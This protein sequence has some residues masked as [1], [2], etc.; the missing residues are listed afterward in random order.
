[1]SVPQR[2][3]PRRRKVINRWIEEFMKCGVV[4]EQIDFSEIPEKQ[5]EKTP[6][7]VVDEETSLGAGAVIE[8]LDGGLYRLDVVHTFR[9]FERF[10]SEH[11]YDEL[12]GNLQI[13]GLKSTTCISLR[14]KARK[15]AGG[16]GPECG[17]GWKTLR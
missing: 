9:D 15:G 13:P 6:I 8:A 16:C 10:M 11:A 14:M 4:C 7:L 1:M 12:I 3:I 5:K 17:N 2:L